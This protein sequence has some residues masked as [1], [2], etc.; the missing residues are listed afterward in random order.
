MSKRRAKRP[1]KVPAFRRDLRGFP[2]FN[3]FGTKWHG[4]LEVKESSIAFEGAHVWIFGQFPYVPEHDAPSFHLAYRD[5]VKLRD[6]LTLFIRAA[7]KDQL[8]EPAL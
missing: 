2:I 5:A 7:D 6:A 4:N 8:C 1:A 3:E